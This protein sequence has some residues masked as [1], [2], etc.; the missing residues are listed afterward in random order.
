MG[1]GVVTE[2]LKISPD[3]RSK[4]NKNPDKAMP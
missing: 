1:S 4:K 2:L 3:F